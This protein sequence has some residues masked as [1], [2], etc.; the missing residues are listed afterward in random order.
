VDEFVGFIIPWIT[1]LLTLDTIL[2][3]PLRY[4]ADTIGADH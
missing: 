4:E 2:F 1:D 3:G